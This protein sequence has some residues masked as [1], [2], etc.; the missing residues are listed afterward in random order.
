MFI[1]VTQ[2]GDAVAIPKLVEHPDIR[3]GTLVGQMGKAAPV[4]LFGQQLDQQVERMRR[5]EQRQ[6]VQ[7]IQLGRTET[8]AATAPQGAGQEL[9][10]ERI[11]PM[12][13]KFPEQGG[14]TGLWKKR[15][16]VPTATPRKPL[17]L[18]KSA[19]PGFSAQSPQH[20]HLALHSLTPSINIM[21]RF[22]RHIGVKLTK[23]TKKPA[24]YLGVLP[25]GPYKP[26][27][28]RY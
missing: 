6:Q 27:H 26:E 8:A 12:R 28:Y 19:P 9:V 16:H 15:F 4:A 11:G 13:G 25:E 1:D 21:R 3:K 24:D 23:L 7:P 22:A 2:A 20:K 5:R 14:R 18:Q 17:C 10:H